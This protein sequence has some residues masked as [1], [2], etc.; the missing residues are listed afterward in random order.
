MMWLFVTGAGALLA[1]RRLP[2]L[3]LLLLGYGSEAVLDPI[4]ARRHEAPRYFAR[5]RPVQL[6]VPIASLLLLLATER[7]RSGGTR[8]K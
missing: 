2:A 6:L 5:L 7:E 3:A 8:W 4:A 1:P